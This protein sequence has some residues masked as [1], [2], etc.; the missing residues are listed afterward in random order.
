MSKETESIEDFSL[1]E[2]ENKK[3]LESIL[4][5]LIEKYE[6]DPKEFK[7][8]FKSLPLYIYTKIDTLAY[9]TSDTRGKDLQRIATKCKKVSKW[10]HNQFK[11]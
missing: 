6:N 7:I 5:E 3:K 1:R 2:E 9:T 11:K 8:S 4:D 10:F